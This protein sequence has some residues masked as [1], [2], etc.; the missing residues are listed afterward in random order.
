[1]NTDK[2]KQMAAAQ[3]WDELQE[4]YGLLYAPVDTK[5]PDMKKAEEHLRMCNEWLLALKG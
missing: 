5:D 3:A 2:L 1:M 4:A